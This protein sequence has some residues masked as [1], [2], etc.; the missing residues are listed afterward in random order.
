MVCV[1]PISFD[2][3]VLMAMSLCVQI[4]KPYTGSLIPEKF[5]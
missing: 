1:E 2:F 4:F 5:H 3:R